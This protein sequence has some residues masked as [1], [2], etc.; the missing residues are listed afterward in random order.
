MKPTRDMSKAQFWAAV[1]KA[2][3]EP[4]LIG[5][6]INVTPD[7]KGGGVNVYRF[8]VGT[9]LRAQLRYLQQQADKWSA[10]K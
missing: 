9:R 10:E 2:G 5:G 6:Y 4:E 7:G 1:K 8:N 3:W